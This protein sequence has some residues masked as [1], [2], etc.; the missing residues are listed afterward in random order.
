MAIGPRRRTNQALKTLG[1]LDL[2]DLP[3]LTS[4]AEL[5]S[6]LIGLR[7]RAP[8]SLACALRAAAKWIIQ[9]LIHASFSQ[10][11]TF[12][13]K[14]NWTCPLTYLYVRRTLLL[15]ERR[16]GNDQRPSKAR[17]H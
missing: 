6:A 10:A 4:P 11:A 3:R 1:L 12:C 7:Q 16:Y 8:A 5:T 15:L 2:L 13:P 14:D 17:L 9:T